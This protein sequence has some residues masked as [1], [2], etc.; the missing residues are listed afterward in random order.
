MKRKTNVKAGAKSNN[1]YGHTVFSDLDQ[2][3]VAEYF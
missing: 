1:S 2:D 3:E